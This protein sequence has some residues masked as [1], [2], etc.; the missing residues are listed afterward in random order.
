M[1]FNSRITNMLH[2]IR[3]DLVSCVNMVIFVGII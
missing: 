3:F 2:N 1:I